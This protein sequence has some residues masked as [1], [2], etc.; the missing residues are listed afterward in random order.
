MSSPLSSVFR[1]HKKLVDCQ[2]FDKDHIGLTTSPAHDRRGIHV[3]LIKKALNSFARRFGMD[4]L[5]DTNDVFD[6]ETADL[7]TTFKALHKPQILNF[8]GKI[9]AV[10]GKKTI[11]ALDDELP[12]QPR[13]PGDP[14]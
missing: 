10:V 11:T 4:E 9:D 5:D 7:V 6:Q 14:R 3:R 13:L 12:F 8:M 1:H 2:R